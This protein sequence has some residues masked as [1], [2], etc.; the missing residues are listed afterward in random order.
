MI[1]K[2]SF[3]QLRNLRKGVGSVLAIFPRSE[4][5]DPSKNVN[6][7]ASDDAAIRGDINRIAMDMSDVAQKKWTEYAATRSNLERVQASGIPEQSIGSKISVIGVGGAGGAMIEHMISSGVK[8]MEYIYAN[9]DAQALSGSSAH[10]VIQLGTRGL[11]AGGN[12][13]IGRDAALAMERAIRSAIE[14]TNIL[15]VVAGLGGGTGTGAAPIIARVAREMGILTVGLVTKPFEFEGASRI[16]VANNGLIALKANVDSL[17][18]LSLEKLFEVLGD[19]V[20]Q[21]QAFANANDKLKHAVEGFAWVLNFP[22]HVNIDFEDF[23]VMASEPGNSMLGVG[24]A[25]GPDRARVASLQAVAPTLFESIDISDAK[26]VLVIIA[27]AKGSLKLSESKLAMNT[28]REYASPHAHV[29]YGTSLDDQLGDNIQVTVM[30]TGIPSPSLDTKVMRTD[31]VGGNATMLDGLRV[32][33]DA[34]S[35]TAPTSGDIDELNIP[36][37]FRKQRD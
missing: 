15:F 28:V 8:G 13:A 23:R 3:R 12:P 17:T 6:G 26:Y 18:V 4:Y 14:G 31:N 11:G 24:L 2:R 19:D 33:A 20:S 32:A 34:P 30:A 1:N 37:F 7:F 22:G 29:I 36:T 9:T 5:I 10:R 21:D 16:A 25:S 35:A 27:A